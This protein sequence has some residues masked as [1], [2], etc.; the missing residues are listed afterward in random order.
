MGDTIC[1]PTC[2]F[3]IFFIR[4]DFSTL[5]LTSRAYQFSDMN[6]LTKYEAPVACR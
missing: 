3:A 6:T 2:N 1:G 4:L 5:I